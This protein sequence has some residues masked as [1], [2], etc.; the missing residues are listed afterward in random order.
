MF[1]NKYLFIFMIMILLVLLES[2][3]VKAN[4]PQ[5]CFTGAEFSCE[6][7][8]VWNDGTLKIRIINNVGKE[9]HDFKAVE[10]YA[11][12]KWFL[13]WLWPL[14]YRGNCS[15]DKNNFFVN[16]LIEITCK[17]N[18]KHIRPIGERQDFR[19]RTEFLYEGEDT[20][21]IQTIKIIPAMIR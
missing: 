2:F 21:K 17:F 15:S 7:Y 4:L 1:T 19:V 5:H 16:E 13:G 6:E 20:K 14:W 18:P 9:V 12:R 10:G 11:E 8:G 3:L